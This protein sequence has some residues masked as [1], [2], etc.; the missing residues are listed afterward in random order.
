MT[1]KRY[2]LF[3][4][5]VL[6]AV[7]CSES[8]ERY[9]FDLPSHFPQPQIPESNPMTLSKIEL[10]RYLFYDTRLSVNGTTSCG[11]CH[12]QKLA[13]TDGKALAVGATGDVL[14]RSSM[15]LTNIV[16]SAR[17]TWANHLLGDL[18]SQML[19]PL[20]G[21]QPV[22]M[23]MAGKEEEML[24]LARS[25]TRYMQLFPKAF[26]EQDD[27]FTLDN[28]TKAIASF[29]RTLISSNSPYDRYIQGDQTA[30][31]SSA[32]RGMT[33]FFDERLECF[34][35][36]GNFN[37]SDSV[38]HQ[39]KAL[40][41]ISFHNNGLYHLD[42]LGSYPEGNQGIFELTGIDAD[43]GRFKAPT[44]RNIEVTAPYMH[45]GSIET[46]EGVVDHYGQGGRTILTGP[47][48]GVGSTN[49]NKSQFVP[50]FVLTAEEKED[51]LSFLKSLTDESFLNDPDFSNP[52][53]DGDGL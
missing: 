15:G 52:F 21:E 40:E 23:G 48:Q 26:P 7:H 25:D 8:E 36:H 16:F 14:A 31:S 6:G 4:L 49:P 42:D 44:L 45:D 12:Q 38:S 39:G 35:C 32:K 33:L 37:F 20:F 29:Q 18:E 3:L 19:V 50:G 22:E 13:F 10:G 24:A 47:N 30:L 27:P 34:H 2:I 11:S 46:L 28:L 17:L 9:A 5:S 53:S 51:V 41:E 43:K 1:Y